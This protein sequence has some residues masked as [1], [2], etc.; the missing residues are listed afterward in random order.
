MKNGKNFL[1]LF[2]LIILTVYIFISCKKEMNEDAPVIPAFSFITIDFSGLSMKKDGSVTL[3]N[4]QYSSISLAL[5]NT[6]LNVNCSIPLNAFKQVMEQRAV[7][8]DNNVWEWKCKFNADSVI[9][10]A[11]L[12]G[13]LGSDSIEW[14]LFIST[15]GSISTDNFLWVEGKS[16]TDQTGGWW[17]FNENQSNPSSYLKVLWSKKDDNSGTTKCIYIKANDTLTN[18]FIES[19]STNNS[20]FDSYYNI[21]LYKNNQI[22]IEYN[23]ANKEGRMKSL[24]I[25]ND[26]NW[27]CWNSSFTNIVCEN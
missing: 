7:N 18:S 14:K 15:S 23:K 10:N 21:Q 17:L 9:V 16:A 27:H 19:G 12:Q 4:F 1:S 20:L 26:N 2:I 5:W 22:N 3:S 13:K 6:L 24:F 25:F 11:T 8:I